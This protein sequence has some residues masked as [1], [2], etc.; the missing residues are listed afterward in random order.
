MDTLMPNQD[1]EPFLKKVTLF[2]DLSGNHQALRE[3]SNIMHPQFY[4]KG[5]ILI[6]QGQSG[7]EFFVLIRGDVSV[8]KKTPDGDEY[9]VALLGSENSPAFGEGGLMEGEVRSATILCE[10]DA[11]CLVLNK[12]DFDLFSQNKPEWALPIVKRI[13]KSIMT[14]LN[15]TSQDLILLH[16]ALMKEIRSS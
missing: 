13:A 6:E 4:K 10:S 11:T 14:R 15:Q 7:D 9:K 2:S 8:S 1:W 12:K 16:Q 3:L 5:S